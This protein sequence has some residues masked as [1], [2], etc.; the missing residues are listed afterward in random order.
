MKK[1]DTTRPEEPRAAEPPK[2]SDPVPS[3]KKSIVDS[4]GKEFT[5]EDLKQFGDRLIKGLVDNL[6]RNAKDED[7]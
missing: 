6:N 5:P 1:E 7:K 2:P 4:S 3:P